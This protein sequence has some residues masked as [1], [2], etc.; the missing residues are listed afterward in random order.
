MNE[1]WKVALLGAAMYLLLAPLVRKY[2]NVPV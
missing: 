1:S 2:A